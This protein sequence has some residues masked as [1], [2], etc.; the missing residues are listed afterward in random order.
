MCIACVLDRSLHHKI[1]INRPTIGGY[2][3]NHQETD[4]Y[5]QFFLKKKKKKGGGNKE[6]THQNP[7]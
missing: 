4:N 3:E 7:T 6:E 2:Q 5:R 1:L